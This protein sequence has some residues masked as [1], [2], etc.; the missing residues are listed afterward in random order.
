MFHRFFGGIHPSGSIGNTEG[1]ELA[2]DAAIEA[3]PAPGVVTIPLSQHIGAPCKPCVKPGDV[4]KR[5]QCIATTD[6]FLHADIHASVAGKVKKIEN[7]AVLIENDGTDAWAEGLPLQRDWHAMEKDELLAAIRDAGIVGMGGATFPA[8]VKLQPKK[9]VDVLILNG[10]ECEPFLTADDRLMREEPDCV[11]EG[12][13]ILARVLSVRRIVI[14]VEENKPEAAE[15]LS[16]A[17]EA[18]VAADT[19]L[20]KSLPKIEVLTLPTRYPEG[21]EKMLIYAVTGRE[22]PLGG[23]P[24]D[25]GAVVQNVGTAAAVFDACVHGIPLIERVTT[26]SGD[27][28][29]HPKNLRVRIG[30]SYQDAIDYCGGFSETPDKI[31]AGG[32]MMG[33]A[34][35][36]L[37]VPITKGSSGILAL[38]RKITEHGPE[39]HCIRCGRCVR[40]C[41]MG[42]V[43]S[44][45]SILGQRKDV[46]KA[47]DDYGV[48]NCIECGCCTYVCPAK[49]NIVQY[50]RVT[51]GA[52]KALAAKEKA[53][54]QAREAAAKAK[55]EKAK[56][57]AKA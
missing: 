16:K 8:F 19:S 10:S 43:P 9:N 5:G 38:T 42:L 20:D 45:L 27:A 52:V 23:L 17:A 53:K 47:R 48:M 55:E 1:K 39:L 33:R 14:A 28:I 46:V 56:E 44:M 35:E 57:A 12:A 6:A 29:A 50:I 15:A 32:P 13:R 54:A 2:R 26:V 18:L 41:P 25:A 7:G 36:S 3:M 49:R 21:A 30:T 37:D 22:V 40:A 31:L 34:Q 11:A 4:V 24:M 51:K